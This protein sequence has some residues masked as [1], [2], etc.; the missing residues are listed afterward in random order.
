MLQEW[1]K[2]SASVYEGKSPRSSL[3]HCR[4]ELV[5]SLQGTT[6]SGVTPASSRAAEVITF[7]VEPGAWPAETARLCPLG[8]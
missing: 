5:V 7:I 6:V 1:L 8:E 3:C 4:G 2:S